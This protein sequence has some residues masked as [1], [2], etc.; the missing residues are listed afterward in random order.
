MI[1]GAVSGAIAEAV[2]SF[3]GDR[4]TKHLRTVI[5][6]L[7]VPPK[8]DGRGSRGRPIVPVGVGSS[9]RGNLTPRLSRNRT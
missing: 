3:P 2:G 6:A 1:C 5:G 9:S 4:S 7:R 8:L